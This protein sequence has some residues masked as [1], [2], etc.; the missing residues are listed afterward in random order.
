MAGLPEPTPA[1][2]AMCLAWHQGEG[3]RA[4]D[5]GARLVWW[6]GRE[7]MRRG[8]QAAS[9]AP[10]ADGEAL[11]LVAAYERGVAAGKGGPYA[12]PPAQ[13]GELLAAVAQHG[14]RWRSGS[15]EPIT[16]ADRLAWLDA[17]ASE[18]AS[19]LLGRD[20]KERAF[21]SSFGPRGFARWLNETNT[22][23][24]GT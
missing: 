8:A 3:R 12:C 19:W 11:A 24:V 20:E 15:G 23:R 7:R 1:D 10:A 4:E 21:Y 18:F 22:R 9:G 5:W 6:M 14:R 17:K 16:G 2:A 13:H